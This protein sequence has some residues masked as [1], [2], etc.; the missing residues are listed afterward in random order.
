MV[1]EKSKQ[2]HPPVLKK[3]EDASIFKV[4]LKAHAVVFKYWQYI[5]TTKHA[6]LPDKGTDVLVAGVD[7]D[8]IKAKEKNEIAFTNLTFAFADP[9]FVGMVVVGMTPEWPEGAA[10]LV[11]E[12]FY[13]KYV[14]N[15]MVAEIETRNRLSNLKIKANEDPF[16]F[17]AKVAEIRNRAPEVKIEEREIISLIVQKAPFKYKSLISSEM[18]R[19]GTNMTLNG[20]S[21]ALHNHYRLMSCE[22]G[23]AESDSDSEKEIALSTFNGSCFKCKKKGHKANECP[24]GGNNN[25]GGNNTNKGRGGGNN[26]SNNNNNNSNKNGTGKFKGKCN[27]CGKVG[28]MAKDCW[29]DDANA[30]KR[31]A[32][33][34]QGGSK[35]TAAATIEFLLCST[36]MGNGLRDMLTGPNL[37]IFDSAATRHVTNSSE[38]MTGL[39]KATESDNMCLSNQ[40]E[41]A[42]AQIGTLKGT[43][44]GKNGSNKHAVSMS[45]VAVMPGGF[46]L[47]S[48]SAVTEKGWTAGGNAEMCW[49]EKG[50]QKIVFDIKIKTKN[51]ALFC[52]NITRVGQHDEVAAL[53]IQQAHSQFGHVNED[54][55]RKMAK[56]LGL[57]LTKGTFG[58]CESCAIGKAKQKNVPKATD[59]ESRDDSLKRVYMDI[60]SI[61]N[62]KGTK[63]VKF[64]HWHMMVIGGINL[65]FSKFYETKNGM[66][67]P[68]C[69]QL[70][71]WAQ[72]GYGIEAIRMDNAK[73]NKALQKR[74]KSADW[75]LPI[76]FEYT[77]RHTPQENSPV[78]TGFG[79]MAN[80]ARAMMVEAMVPYQWRRVLMPEACKTATKLDGLT[81]VQWQGKEATRYEHWCGQNP[82][83]ANHLRTW[84]EAGTVTVKEKMAAKV[85]D[86][87]K[88]CMM[89]GYAD[90]HA[91]DVYRLWT[92]VTRAV[93]ISRDVTWLN[94]MF[95]TEKVDEAVTYDSDSES[96]KETIRVEE[97]SQAAEVQ[98]REKQPRSELV[99]ANATTMN[100]GTT[101]SGRVIRP[102]P[103]LLEQVL[104]AE[105]SKENPD[106]Q[107]EVAL[108]TAMMPAE[109]VLS[110]AEEKFYDALEWL[111]PEYDEWEYANVGAGLGG[112][113]A[114][115]SELHV[116]KYDEAMNMADKKEVGEWHDAVMEEKERMDKHVVFKAVPLEKVPEGAKILTSTW[117]MKKKAN[118]KKRARLNARGFEQVDGE[119]YS[120]DN[121]AAPVV[122]LSTIMMLLVLIVMLGWTANLVD[123]N[124]A[125]LLGEFEDGLNLFMHVPQGFER[126]Y[127][128]NVVLLLLKTLYG[129]KQSAK[130]FWVKLLAVLYLMEFKRGMADPCLYFQWTDEGLVLIASWVDDLLM[131]GN[132]AL[133]MKV[134]KQLF[135]HLDC[136]D[137]GEL[138]EYVGCKIERDKDSIRLTQPVLLQS[139]EDEFE[140][141]MFSEVRTP[142]VAGQVLQSGSEG[143]IVSA[144]EQTTYRSGVGKLLHLM[145]WS[146]PEIQNAVR[147]LSRFFSGASMAHVSAMYRVMTY[148]L[149]SKNRGRLLKPE[150]KC[151]EGELKTFKFRVKGRSDS[152]F[153]TDPATRRSVTGYSV[154]LEG[155]PTATKSKMQECVT[156]SVTEA[157][158]V[159]AADCAQEM[160]FQKHVLESIGLHVELPMILEIDNKGAIDLA[161][162]WGSS[163]R[164]KHVDVRHH[165]LRE[166]KEEGIL[167]FEWIGTA[168]NS[169]D[170]FTKNVD[171]STYEKHVAV[172]CGASQSKEEG[173]AG[174]DS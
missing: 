93:Y 90:D 47:F 136:D 151:T 147:E 40:S 111:E 139:F 113:F 157:E 76:K 13:Q 162:N 112:G 65:K 91:G 55:T 109:L 97:G 79:T 144:E 59:L 83:F 43:L 39:R 85:D 92:P 110:S 18:E 143:A 37:F 98:G 30:G 127:P 101:R 29:D 170:I 125:F 73:E 167:K 10:W 61:K 31:P 141:P 25:N 60:A 158:Y 103:K 7:D 75:K 132:E 53:T 44:S 32:W 69:E 160:L 123:V 115:T 23:K 148:C 117:A 156:T 119:H 34:K 41:G 4:Q 155:A 20:L 22:E 56:A 38:A 114:D 49:V 33:F 124:G 116:M 36:S 45:E 87:G 63:Q 173:V 11:M 17:F 89:I 84:G 5:Q 168:S 15:D 48:M 74:C 172:Y 131:C 163:G 52:A 149:S 35:E 64:R 77:A 134:K 130:R 126:F 169:S 164:T 145:R 70:S 154:F 140:I 166:L 129:C 42:V 121:K 46:N 6:D 26:S 96:V 9:Q 174:H 14:P 21:M 12:A 102:T 67:E 161:N 1:D 80:R 68:T 19:L 106:E 150:R 95:F 159:S 122:A 78:E 16:D 105:E 3:P 146:R 152:N 138:T 50:D 28:H 165:F 71:K 24:G 66:I 142:A 108:L 72:E 62:Q 153:A 94:R 99:R 88:T 58:V 171:V 8:K 27:N 137:V 107:L 86:R 81:V 2:F 128:K 57:E 118:G 82:K 104:E 54:A 120:E 133:V 100:R 135:E 51:G